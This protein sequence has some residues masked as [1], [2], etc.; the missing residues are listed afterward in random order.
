MFIGNIEIKG[1][2]ALAPMAGVADHAFRQMCKEYGAAY[3]VGE[4][5]SSKGLTMSGRKTEELLA[6]TDF[7]RPMGVQIF[8]DD[9]ETMA[10][11]AYKCLDFSPDIIDINMGCPA[12]KVASNGG[13]SALM[14]NP[15]LAGEIVKA[16][17]KAVD[18]PVTVKF[19]KGWDEKN[20]NA[21][22]FAKIVEASGASAVTVHGRTRVQMYAGKVDKDI[23]RDVKQAVSVPVIASG[24]VVDGVSA[25]D[26]YDYTGADLV[27]V[28][29]GA[30]G[31]PWVFDNISHYLETG[32]ILAEPDIGEKLRVMKR[33]IELICKY[34]TET[35][36]MR[37][38]R[39]HGAW[40]IKGIKGAAEYRRI[41]GTLK[42][43][44]DLDRVIEM[45]LV[46][47]NE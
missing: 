29:R 18:V 10:K 44:S 47:E 20:V 14:K 35:F 43:M 30:Y 24:D 1:K 5:A 19:R 13:G 33:H 4:M 8:G 2:I 31:A 36:G 28:G 37:E 11:A 41:M 32:E 15:T 26:M 9:P 27:M 42:S 3:M 21:V 25:K 6:V 45:I 38:A 22:E 34:K 23:I 17:S 7:E 40:Y 39:K 46:E 16:V 12:P